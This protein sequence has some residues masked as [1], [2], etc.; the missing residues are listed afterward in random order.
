M[1]FVGYSDKEIIELT[2]NITYDINSKSPQQEFLAKKIDIPIEYIQL[3]IYDNWGN[4]DFTC[5]YR[6]RVHSNQLL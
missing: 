4:K 6:F 3:Q 1:K 5:L 2:D